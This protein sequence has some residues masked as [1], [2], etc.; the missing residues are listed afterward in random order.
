MFISNSPCFIKSLLATF[1]CAVAAIAWA[2]SAIGRKKP[3]SKCH[4]FTSE[5]KALQNQ[6]PVAKSFHKAV[7]SVGGGVWPP[8]ATH[9]ASW[10]AQLRPFHDIYIAISSML[11]VAKSDI[12]LDDETNCRKIEAF[13][14]KF[15]Q[16]L[17]E[18]IDIAEVQIILERAELSASDELPSD[19][20]NGFYACIA[21]SRHAFRWGIIPVVKAAQNQKLIAFPDELSIPWTYISRRYGVSSMGGNVMSNYLYNLDDNNSVVYEINSAVEKPIQVAEQRFTQIF[22][23]LEVQVRRTIMNAENLS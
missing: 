2:I 10:P 1:L 20:Y 23:D 22:H 6:H 9:G 4:T 14:S 3:S 11:A 16:L 7:S 5:V 8:K 21:M 13:R 18:K 12:S 19:A 17:R 15:A